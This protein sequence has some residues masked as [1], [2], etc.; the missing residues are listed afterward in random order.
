MDEMKTYESGAEM[1]LRD[2]LAL[3]RTKL[4]N[5]RTLLAYLRMGIGLVA[6]GIGM[7]GI[8]DLFWAHIVGWCFLAAAPA[9][10]ITGVRNFA[11][12]K[13]KMGLLDKQDASHRQ[14]VKE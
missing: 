10:L 13:K 12:M 9:A 11:R 6:A 5:E 3:D 8:L 4:A 7:I 2:Y 1:I 14:Q